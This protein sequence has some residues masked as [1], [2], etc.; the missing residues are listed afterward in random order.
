MGAEKL[1]IK[2]DELLVEDKFLLDMIE[3]RRNKMALKLKTN[4]GKKN[5]LIYK[6]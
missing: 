1:K 6:R 4:L 2:F 5:L 3:E